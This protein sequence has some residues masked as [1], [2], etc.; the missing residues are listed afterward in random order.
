MDVSSKP[1]LMTANGE[2]LVFRPREPFIGWLVSVAAPVINSNSILSPTIPHTL[3]DASLAPLVTLPDGSANFRRVSYKMSAFLF[4]ASGLLATLAL[5]GSCAGKG[6]PYNDPAYSYAPNERVPEWL[7]LEGY[8]DAREFSVERVIAPG[9]THRFETRADIPI[10]VN[11]VTIDMSETGLSIETESGQDDLFKRETLPAM[12]ERFMSGEE[13]LGVRGM[14]RSGVFPVYS[15]TPVVLANADFWAGNSA[16]INLFVDEGVIWRGPWYGDEGQR[17][18]V[19]AFDDQGNYFLGLPEFKAELIGPDGE[20]LEINGITFPQSSGPVTAYTWKSGDKPEAGDDSYTLPLIL[21]SS[22]WLPNTPVEVMNG[23]VVR[24]MS[25]PGRT[26]T[27]HSTEEFPKWATTNSPLSLSATL[28]GLPGKVVGAVG[29]GPQLLIDGKKITLKSASAERM[30]QSFVETWHPRTAVGIK[31]DGRTLVIVTV[32]GRQPGR[33]VGID[34]FDL[35][36]IMK[37]AG[38]VSAMNLDGGGSTSLMVRNELANFPSDGGGPRA[39]TN[40]LVVSHSSSPGGLA[41]IDIYPKNATV[42]ESSIVPLVLRGFDENGEP[43]N[44]DGERF[45]WRVEQGNARIESG[46]LV[47]EEGTEPV[48]IRVD[49]NGVT[50]SEVFLPS[51]PAK[52]SFVPDT[53]MMKSD[54]TVRIRLAAISNDGTPFVGHIPVESINVPDFVAIRPHTHTIAGGGVLP[55][56]IVAQSKGVGVI[57]AN[58]LGQ[59]ISLPLAVDT[60]SGETAFGFEELVSADMTSWIK[61][62]RHDPDATTVMLETE[63]VKEGNTAWQFHYGMV[64]GGT[65]K[66]ELPVN[67]QLTND[68]IGVGLWVFGDGKK[69]WL[70]GELRDAENKGYYLNFTNSGGIDWNN[71]W[72]FITVSVNDFIPMGGY[73]NAPVPPFTVKGVYVAQTQEAAKSSGMILL[74]GLTSVERPTSE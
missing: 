35:A 40:A 6:I 14:T 47:V 71:K 51:K 74:D 45:N 2:N 60:V 49:G 54:D 33:A 48:T 67:A 58:V 62:I 56:E 3:Y 32:D 9:V 15:G 21:P 65:T 69:Q 57:E 19:F 18:P 37:E 44:I 34:L 26:V 13:E 8:H 72:K 59:T 66:I 63:N 25:P 38:C 23:S 55:A 70:R 1:R 5:L 11:T 29:G 36:D 64:H 20:T 24:M 10:T 52:I 53:L 17:R 27:L 4:R 61:G 43:V 31:E 42:A 41:Q 28:D 73:A 39:V 12:Y 46:N 50:D 16:P 68:A 22:E 30:S 7:A